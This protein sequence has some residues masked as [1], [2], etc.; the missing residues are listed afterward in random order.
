M[1]N[2]N[3]EFQITSY[4]QNDGLEGDCGD[5][6]LAWRSGEMKDDSTD[7]TVSAVPTPRPDKTKGL[8]GFVVKVER[9]PVELPTFELKQSAEAKRRTEEAKKSKGLGKGGPMGGVVDK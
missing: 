8:P 3:G 6:H 2:D 7:R 9:K 4:T 5:N 1:T